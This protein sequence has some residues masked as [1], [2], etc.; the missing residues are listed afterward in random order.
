MD[1]NRTAACLNCR[2]L[3]PPDTPCDR[4]PRHE[5]ARLDEQSGRE[6][7]SHRVWTRPG[8][9]P[10]P[11]TAKAAITAVGAMG[12]IVLGTAFGPLAALGGA[13]L[14][15]GPL[16]LSIESRAR[17]PRGTATYRR[18]VRSGSGY[19]GTVSGAADTRAPLTDRPCLA[20]ALFLR[21]DPNRVGDIMLVDSITT[22]FT[23]DCD[24]G[25]RVQVPP[26]RVRLDGE[27]DKTITDETPIRHFLAA[28][29]EKLI[30]PYEHGPVP[31]DRAT[32]VLLESG[33]RVHA[34][35]R[36]TEIAMSYRESAK[37][38]VMSHVPRVRIVD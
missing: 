15:G 5:V 6:A 2:V 18:Q 13:A 35:G 7:L 8:A 4:S 10:L 36:T 31:H 19:V 25:R 33:D 14:I 27:H 38:L 37:N 22:G 16:A 20:Y 17:H 34:F 30:A 29:D 3:L 32:E 28:I 12:M 1:V 24:D 11:F 9:L 26:G 21:K 23:I